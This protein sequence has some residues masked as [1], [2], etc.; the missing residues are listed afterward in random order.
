MEASE[1]TLSEKRKL[2]VIR[3]DQLCYVIFTSGSTGKPKGVLGEH[4]GLLNMSINHAKLANMHS[5]DRVLQF[6]SFSFD[7]FAW[8]VFSTLSAGATLVMG[9]EAEIKSVE[10]IHQLLDNHQI[11]CVTLPPSYLSFLKEDTHALRVVVS[12]GEPL[13][14]DLATAFIEK[15]V[16]IINAYGPTENTVCSTYSA[17]PIKEWGITIGKPLEGTKVYI[18]DSKEEICPIGCI[19][20]LCVSGIQVARGYLKRNDLTASNFITNPYDTGIYGKL[21]KTGD[22]ARWMPDGNIQFLGRRDTQV[23]I[24]GYRVELQEIAQNIRSVSSIED[25]VVTLDETSQTLSAY[26]VSSLNDETNLASLFEEVNEHL[27]KVLP[28]YM[29][30]SNYMQIANIPLTSNGKIDYKKLPK[31]E[32]QTQAGPISDKERKLIKIYGEVLEIAPESISPESNFFE[33][34]GQSLK[35]MVLVN[36]IE[37]ELNVHLSIDEVFDNPT[38]ASLVQILGNSET[39]LPLIIPKAEKREYY[40]VSPAQRR[41]FFLYQL[42]K[43]ATNYNMPQIY[44]VSGNPDTE[45]LMSVFKKIVA[46]HESLRT[47]FHIL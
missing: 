43:T 22:L 16:Q 29:I 9:A 32:S 5:E 25:A 27:A 17:D 38:V 45:F 36:T 47:T 23:K 33:L 30:P 20:E 44:E 41:M 4:K 42:D 3:P 34:G 46:R 39:S 21:Y 37:K 31:P 28:A 6:A 7:A 14:A 10:K 24:R 35:A 2:P 8:E 13:T 1:E 18:L 11:N 26:I 40:P 15:G 12:A 19:G